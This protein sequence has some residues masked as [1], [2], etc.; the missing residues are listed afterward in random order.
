M[1]SPRVRL[2]AAAGVLAA[3]LLATPTL[4][5]DAPEQPK[6]EKKAELAPD[7]PIATVNGNPITKGEFDRSLQAFLANLQRFQR[8]APGKA[9]EVTEKMKQ[10]V[11]D[12]L[13]DR[14][15]L[16]EESTKF[17]VEDA[18]KQVAE[19]FEKIQ[20]RFPDAAAFQKA[21]ESEGLTEAGLKDLLGRQVSVR[22]YVEKQ[23]VP[24]VS[25]PEEDVAKFYE[26]N[27]EKFKVPEQVRCSHILIRVLPTATAEEKEAARKKA[28]DIQVRCAAGEDFAAL[29][30]EFSEDP[31]SGPSGGDLGFFA[32][33]RMVKP[34]AEAAFA[35]KVGEVSE[36][37][38]SPYGFH[39]IKMTERKDA[40]QRSLDDVKDQIESYLKAQVLDAKVR[41][42][43]AEL[44][45]DAK[46]EVVAPEL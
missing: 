15:L 16:Y 10:D 38:E 31:G 21:Y 44:K 19:E 41:A 13:V 27:Q 3:C 43:I 11:L 36:V 5:A 46:I 14:E 7:A 28:Q 40:S 37:V 24:Q 1:K 17:P 30:K 20:S 22:N 8:T 32:R 29:A 9:P 42:Q 33:D 23:I 25:V 26:E 45:K 35:L 4:A 12:Q 2:T 6:A 34:F 39:I 18:D